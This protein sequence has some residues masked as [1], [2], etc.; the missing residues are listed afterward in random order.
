MS[1]GGILAVSSRDNLIHLLE[2]LMI[3]KKVSIRRRCFCRG[4][5]APVQSLDFSLDGTYLMA[6]DNS[7]ELLFWQVETGSRVNAVA[8]RDEVWYSWSSTLGW[9]VMG[10]A[11]LPQN[12]EIGN[13]LRFGDINCAIRS[14]DKT[15]LAV[16]SS[17]RQAIRLFPY[18]CLNDSIPKAYNGHSSPVVDIVF[19]QD[20]SN[21]SL[22][23]VSAGGNDCCLFQWKVLPKERN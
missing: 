4:H 11:N 13:G 14:P 9:P 12:A 21:L 10:A 17:Q 1:E 18:P 16:G 15:L 19:L 22:S 5:T 8:L 3:N 6:A 2:V 7:K 20:S 23:V